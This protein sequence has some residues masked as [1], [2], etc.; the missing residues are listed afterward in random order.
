MSPYS[1]GLVVGWEKTQEDGGGGG[2]A[3]VGCGGVDGVCGCGAM[4]ETPP[5]LW[6]PAT[7]GLEGTIKV[8]TASRW[9]Y[10]RI[11]DRTAVSSACKAW[12]WC[13]RAD[14]APMHPYTGSLSL[15]F[16]SYTRLFAASALWFSGTSWLL[17]KKIYIRR[18]LQNKIFYFWRNLTLNFCDQ[19][20]NFFYN[21][22]IQMIIDCMNMNSHLLDIHNITIV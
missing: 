13:C 10:L 7:W 4:T 18:I 22:K 19:W 11:S 5:E 2:W 14:I 12:T 20:F 9:L 21:K 16:A 1:N 3:A 8:A 17:L 6:K 15:T